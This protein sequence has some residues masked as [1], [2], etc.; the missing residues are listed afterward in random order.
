MRIGK[1]GDGGYVL[2]E[3]LINSAEVL[4]GYGVGSDISFELDFLKRKKIPVRLYDH[5]VTDLPAPTMDNQINFVREGLA[6]KKEDQKNS[7]FAHMA[8]WNDEGKKVLLKIDIDGAEYGY[9]KND[10]FENYENVIG[11]ILE[12]H[13]IGNNKDEAISLLG[14]IN[15]KF[16]LVHMHGNNYGKFFLDNTDI[17]P[18][19]IELVYLNKSL[20]LGSKAID[21]NRNPIPLLDFPCN[22][23]VIDFPNIISIDEDG[24]KEVLKLF[25]SLSD[26]HLLALREKSFEQKAAQAHIGN[27]LNRLEDSEHSFHELSINSNSQIEQLNNQIKTLRDRLEDSERSKEEIEKTIDEIKKKQYLR[28]FLKKVT[29]YFNLN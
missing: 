28:N 2:P 7:F 10:P 6:A 23:L 3:L 8:F 1:S 17:F 4:Y 19:T 25:N 13:E 12:L 15:Q 11:L 24:I 26:S 5:T 18:D 14:K 22:D 20:V 16:L 9:F 27:L 29:F 21:L